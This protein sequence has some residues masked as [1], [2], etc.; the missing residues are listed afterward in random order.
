MTDDELAKRNEIAPVPLPVP[1]PA[2]Y[3]GVLEGSVPAGTIAPFDIALLPDDLL[4]PPAPQSE[5]GADE[6]RDRINRK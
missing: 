6:Q 2:Q 3:R 1:P 4:P 5:E